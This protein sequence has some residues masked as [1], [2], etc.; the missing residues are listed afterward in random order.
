MEISGEWISKLIVDFIED[1]P[2]NSLGKDTEQKAWAEPLV[3][4]SNGADP[5]Y[6]FYKEDIGDFILTPHEVFLQKFPGAE[7]QASDLAIVTWI[8]PQTETTKAAQREMTTFP[9]EQWMRAKVFGEKVNDK[10]REYVVNSLQD[11][12][13]RAVAPVLSSTFS[14]MFSEKY[15]Y[16]STW[17]ERHAAYAAGLGTF[18]LCDGLITPRG[19]AMRCGSVVVDIEIPPSNRPYSNHRAYCLYFA[20]ESCTECIDQCPVQAISEEGHDKDKCVHH[21]EQARGRA[22]ERY[23]F[24]SDACGLCQVDVP[25]ESGIPSGKQD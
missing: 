5:L 22:M 17:S 14:E 2:A 25:C 4:F 16:A 23:G 3:G 24:G 7:V 10:L 9:S 18:G 6:E 8:L 12:G 13:Y 11:E 20:D 19:K 21:L 15:N 1:S